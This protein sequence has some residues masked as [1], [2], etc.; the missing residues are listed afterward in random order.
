MPLPLKKQPI[1]RSTNRNRKKKVSPNTITFE[2]KRHCMKFQIQ[3]TPNQENEIIAKCPN[4][5]QEIYQELQN[6][7]NYK[8]INLVKKLINLNP[9]DKSKK[10]RF[11]PFEFINADGSLKEEEEISK[12]LQADVTIFCV[13]LEKKLKF[14]EEKFRNSICN[15]GKLAL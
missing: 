7:L 13:S 5:T 2:V 15:L 12:L 10:N 9:N 6:P 4:W 1:I 3:L 8:K 11:Q 14:A